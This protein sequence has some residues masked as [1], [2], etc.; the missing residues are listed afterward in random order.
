[1][2]RVAY[3][4]VIDS[5]ESVRPEA[6][7]VYDE[8]ARPKDGRAAEKTLTE[9]AAWSGAEPGSDGAFHF[10]E[11]ARGKEELAKA[12]AAVNLSDYDLGGV[13]FDSDANAT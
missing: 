13:N 4:A 3:R 12:R 11:I 1:M 6:V 10:G 2:R 9:L 7:P 5:P 8:S